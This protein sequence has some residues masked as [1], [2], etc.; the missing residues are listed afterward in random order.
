M[1]QAAVLQ[2]IRKPVYIRRTFYARQRG[3]LALH[4]SSLAGTYGQGN[5]QFVYAQPSARLV[6]GIGKPKI[7][8]AMWVESDEWPKSFE[9]IAPQLGALAAEKLLTEKSN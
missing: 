6:A 8:N 2:A 5:D 7:E 9:E 4:A 1:K 3:R